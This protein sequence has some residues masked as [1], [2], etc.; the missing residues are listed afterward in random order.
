MRSCSRGDTI[1]AV[2]TTRLLDQFERLIG[3]ESDEDL[4]TAPGNVTYWRIAVTNQRVLGKTVAELGLESLFGVEVTRI[5]RGDVEMTAVPSLRL[6]FGDV[7]QVV[8]TEEQL[9][10]AAD[11]LGNS[12]KKLNETQFIPLF[13][14][15]FLGILVGSIPLAVPGLSNPLRLG[16]AGGPLIV[17]LALAASDTSAA[18]SGTCR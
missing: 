3:R 2:G 13:A 5:T 4:L 12:L 6:Q 15:I 16:L 14:G 9:K 8:G 18:S 10:K 1:L 17:A 7:L 11:L